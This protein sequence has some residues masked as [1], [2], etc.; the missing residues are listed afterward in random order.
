MKTLNFSRQKKH[1]SAFTLIEI[2][3]ATV[4][5]IVLTGLV[6]QITSEVLKVWNRSSGKLSANAEARIAMDL[7]SQDLETAVFRNNG[8]RWLE[9]ETKEIAS[10]AGYQPQTINLLLFSPALDRPIEDKSSKVIPGDI[11]AVQYE[12]VYQ[13]P[14]SGG[15]SRAEDNMF[16]LHRRLIDPSTTFN[17]IMGEGNQETFTSWDDAIVTP[18][19]SL[20]PYPAPEDPQ[21]YLAGHVANF[22][23]DFYVIDNNGDEVIVPSPI[24]FGGTAPT[25]GSSAPS[26][27]FPLAYAEISLTILSDE[28]TKLLQNLDANRGGTGFDF[29]D[30]E[31]IVRQHGEVFTRRVNFLARP[32]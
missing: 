5:M 26:L 6:I 32:L 22:K 23:V 13:N 8:L 4:V 11:C 30:G 10:V 20:D 16:A 25:V 1:Q 27:A 29:G 15:S 14:V 12:L 18:V 7:L 19:V 24:K 21:N 17:Q 2:M 9:A 28:G 31:G 3:V